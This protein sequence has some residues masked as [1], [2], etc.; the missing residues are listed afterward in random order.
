[1]N[2][3]LYS[4]KAKISTVHDVFNIIS[5][6]V[7]DDTRINQRGFG[8]AEDIPKAL[9]K[10]LIEENGNEDITKICLD[11]FHKLVGNF[12]FVEL[13]FQMSATME[14]VES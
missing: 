2:S 5:A 6:F 4:R 7:N 3:F 11:I 10:I 8:H 1:V 12:F 14:F 13:I 9:L